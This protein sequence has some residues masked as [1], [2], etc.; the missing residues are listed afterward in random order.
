M[1]FFPEYEN[2]DGIALAALLARGE[3]SQADL[4]RAAQEGMDRY[5][6]ALNAVLLRLDAQAACQ[7][8][9]AGASPWPACRY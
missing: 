5:N 6:P 2:H 4:L 1:A 3:I 8:L 7:P 9:R